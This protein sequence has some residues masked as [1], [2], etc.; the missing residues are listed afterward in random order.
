M[1]VPIAE[2]LELINRVKQQTRRCR[3][4]SFR[5]YASQWGLSVSPA[6][7]H[8]QGEEQLKREIR[9]RAIQDALIRIEVVLRRLLEL[10]HKELFR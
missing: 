8:A 7:K 1:R 9:D 2:R 3:A 6:R 4:A 10:V 5:E